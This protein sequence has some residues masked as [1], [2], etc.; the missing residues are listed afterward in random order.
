[1]NIR[2]L[3]V[4]DTGDLA[5]FFATLSE[6]DLTLIREEL[7]DPTAAAKLIKGGPCWVAVDEDSRIIGYVGV[8]RLPGWSNH[9]ESYA[10]WWA[11]TG[12]AQGSDA[13]WRSTR[14]RTPSHQAPAS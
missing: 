10:S 7:S 4:A 1:M 3:T 11:R 12:G 5:A 6:R 13:H 9:S 14:S 8:E 2:I